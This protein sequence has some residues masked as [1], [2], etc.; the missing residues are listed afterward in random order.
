VWTLVCRRRD[1]RC[2]VRVW[3]MSMWSCACT[4]TRWQWPTIPVTRWQ[5][6]QQRS[7]SW[8]VGATTGYGMASG[9]GPSAGETILR[10]FCGVKVMTLGRPV[11]AAPSMAFTLISEARHS[12]HPT[13]TVRISNDTAGFA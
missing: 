4:R 9:T 2:A 3:P 5:T 6:G 7:G 10:C 1:C 13:H 8:S 11:V 12:L